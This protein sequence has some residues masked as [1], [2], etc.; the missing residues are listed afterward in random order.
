MKQLLWTLLL[1]LINSPPVTAF[2]PLDQ[3]GLEVPGEIL[4]MITNISANYPAMIP[5]LIQNLAN[6]LLPAITRQ[7]PDIPNHWDL[8][9]QMATQIVHSVAGQ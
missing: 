3:L 2:P 7:L 9:R 6:M 1:A 4:C 8:A 5:I